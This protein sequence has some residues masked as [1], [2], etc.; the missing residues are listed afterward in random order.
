LSTIRN[1][2]E[3][4]LPSHIA[5][6][7]R[8]YIDTVEAALA[9]REQ[10]ALQVIREQGVALGASEAQVEDVLIASGLVEPTPEPVV[11][12]PQTVEAMIASLT[13]EV[14]NLAARLDAASTAAARHGVRF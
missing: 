10:D 7:Y 3:Q 8:S 1:T 12:E 13:E 6:S 14:R 4:A 11:E 9:E 5:S 2:I